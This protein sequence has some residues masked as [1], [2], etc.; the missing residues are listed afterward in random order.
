MHLPLIAAVAGTLET[1]ERIY[2]IADVQRFGFTASAHVNAF[3]RQGDPR[4]QRLLGE[5]ESG[6]NRLGAVQRIGIADDQIGVAGIPGDVPGRGQS[7]PASAAVRK[8]TPIGDT[9]TAPIFQIHT[10]GTL[11]IH[12]GHR[13]I[14]AFGCNSV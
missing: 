1:H 3:R 12:N 4:T 11:R 6:G 14:T 13:N 8:R 10:P 2:R 9:G 5:A 7:Q